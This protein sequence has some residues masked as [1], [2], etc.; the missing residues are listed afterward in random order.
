MNAEVSDT[1]K[2][3][4]PHINTPL[5]F[6]TGSVTYVYVNVFSRDRDLDSFHVFNHI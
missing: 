3:K 2:L 4:L 6:A 5:S 1:I